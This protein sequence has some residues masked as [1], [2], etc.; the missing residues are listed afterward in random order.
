[1]RYTCKIVINLPINK[2]VELWSDEN[3]F[4]EWQD[5]L[6]RIEHIDQDKIEGAKAKIFFDG[7]HKFELLETIMINNLPHEKKA[8]YEHTHMINTQSSRFSEL[9]PGQT[10]YTSEVVYTQFNGIMM[11]VVSKLFPGKF[12]AQ[13]EKWMKQFKE[14]AERYQDKNIS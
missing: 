2:V 14:F 4:K 8:L 11:K 5:G 7:K 9:G 10:E 13:S 3:H 1:M 6:V 12:K